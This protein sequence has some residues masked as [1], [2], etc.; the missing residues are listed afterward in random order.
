MVASPRVIPPSSGTKEAVVRN[1]NDGA[2][3]PKAKKRR[4]GVHSSSWLWL[5]GVCLFI[6]I[7]LMVCLF[8]FHANWMPRQTNMVIKSHIRNRREI[9]KL[10]SG[11]KDAAAKTESKTA[12]EAEPVEEAG[13]ELDSGNIGGGAVPGSANGKGELPYTLGNSPNNDDY[14]ISKQQYHVIFSTGCSD[15]QHWQSYMLY[16]SMVTSGQTGQVTRIASGCTKEE[17]VQLAK[18]HEEQIAPMGMD[19]PYKGKSRFH[20]HMTPEF[21]SGFHYNN[22]PYGVAHWME[23]V[24]GYSEKDKVW[25]TNHDDTILFLLD[26]DMI[27][28]RP[29]VNDFSHT[30]KWLPRKSYPQVDR[31][32][33]GF[34]MASVYLYGDQWFTKTNITA[35]TGTSPITSYTRD[36]IKENYHAGPP[37]VATAKDFFNIVTTWR[38]LAQPV[39]E[40]YPYLLSEMFA[41]SLAAAHLQLPHQLAQSF[42]VSD[43]K[44]PGLDLVT[45]NPNVKSEQMCRH[46]PKETKPHVLHYCQRLA[47]GK[48]IM[49]KHRLPDDFVGQHVSCGKPLLMEPPDDAAVRYDYFI[50]VASGQRHDIRDQSNG[51]K[52]QE[53]INQAAF[54]LC[55]E[56]EAFNRGA[57]YFKQ[58]HCDASE[59]NFEKTFLFF[60]STELTEA[61]K[62][63]AGIVV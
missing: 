20:L 2:Y 59:A 40:Q 10:L 63:Q 17:E 47:L 54:M 7:G 18:I 26:P 44:E 58:H 1:A 61:E 43:W 42:M 5:N 28:M 21:G 46:V 45:K 51:F 16:Y 62:A 36:Q 3:S 9:W 57:T 48:F 33:H 50:D 24:L 38:F 22:K 35:I 49:S 27:M 23:N 6:N 14:D 30:E 19:M 29:F 4:G 37:Y 25:S 52:K 15:K 13:E 55:E 8:I 56:L 53:K 11:K 34:P 32:K 60:D 12:S 39:H 31:I 41:Y